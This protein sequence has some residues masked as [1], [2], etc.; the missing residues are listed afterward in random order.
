M[1]SNKSN[2]NAGGKGIDAADDV[3]EKLHLLETKVRSLEALI[4]DRQPAA[5]GTQGIGN[6]NRSTGTESFDVLFIYGVF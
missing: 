5:Q 4:V 3:E 1:A 2:Y 6:T